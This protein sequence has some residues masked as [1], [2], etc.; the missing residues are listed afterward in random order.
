MQEKYEVPELTIIG[1]VDEVI[2]GSGI[3]GGDLFMQA[4][5]DFEFEQD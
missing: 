1:E 2:L 4:P 5:S 3:G